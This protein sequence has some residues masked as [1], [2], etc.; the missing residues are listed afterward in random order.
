MAIPK[1]IPFEHHQVFPNGA[2][3]VS[4]VTPFY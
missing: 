3:I 1:R 4:E 2:F